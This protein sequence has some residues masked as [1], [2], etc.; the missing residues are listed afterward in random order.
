MLGNREIKHRR[1]RK[2]TKRNG[3]GEGRFSVEDVK[4]KVT[5]RCEGNVKVCLV[6]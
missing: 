3:V 1:K 2:K 6:M 5:V 4:G